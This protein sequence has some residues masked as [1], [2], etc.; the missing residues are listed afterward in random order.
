MNYNSV[1]LYAHC[2]KCTINFC[3]LTYTL[4]ENASYAYSQ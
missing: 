1:S 3:R 4:Q 2:V